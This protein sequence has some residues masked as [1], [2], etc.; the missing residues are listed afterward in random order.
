MMGNTG[1]AAEVRCP[2]NLPRWHVP[3]LDATCYVLAP[4]NSFGTDYPH[5]HQKVTSAPVSAVIE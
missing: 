1:S 5:I 3:Y 2:V 4:T